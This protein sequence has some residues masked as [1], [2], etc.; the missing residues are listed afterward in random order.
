MD[1]LKNKKNMIIGLIALVVLLALTGGVAV[2]AGVRNTINAWINVP[3]EVL[4]EDLGTYLLPE[5][6]VVDANGMIL[7]GYRV[8]LVSVT[9]PDGEV[10]DGSLGSLMVETPGVYEFLYTARRKNV[11]DAVVRVDFGDRTAPSVKV[12]GMFPDFYITGN[13][14]KIPAYTVEG[15]ADRTKCWVK[16]LYLSEKG[17]EQEV[18]VRS[19]QFRVDQSAGSYVVR[20]HVEDSAGN[21]NDYEYARA[22][23]GPQRSEERRVGKECAI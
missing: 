23:D 15:D 21:Y 14:Y 2:A 4:E 12:T 17:G 20:I 6:E 18:E 8:S 9:G 19:N 7:A 11:E 10:L 22:V 13:T 16:V 1:K 3:Q 5:Y